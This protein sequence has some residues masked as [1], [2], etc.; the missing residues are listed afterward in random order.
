MLIKSE[1]KKAVLEALA[2]EHARRILE[3][4][5]FKVKSVTDISRE[6]NIPMTSAYRKV[7]MLTDAGLLRVERFVTTDQGVKY[8]LFSSN[9]K[10]IS[11]KFEAGLLEIDV[12]SNVGASEKMANLF[13]SLEH[14]LADTIWNLLIVVLGNPFGDGAGHTSHLQDFLFPQVSHS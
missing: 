10:S 7:K 14:S 6:C 5:I 9:V 2:D 13:F 3:D 12:T 4:T 8:E 11:V 1:A